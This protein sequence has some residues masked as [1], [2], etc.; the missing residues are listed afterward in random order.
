[1]RDEIHKIVL[2]YGQE[3]DVS[4]FQVIGVLESVKLDLF[5]M[6]SSNSEKRKDET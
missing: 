1:M 6:L 2:R 4:V 3:S 5:E